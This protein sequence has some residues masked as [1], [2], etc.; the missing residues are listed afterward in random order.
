M[1]YQQISKVDKQRI[2]DA[3]NNDE[4]YVE[5]ARL[6][7]IKRTTAWAI[8]RRFLQTGL[9]VR[10]RGGFRQ[11][12]NKV[13]DEMRNALV[14]I[15]EEHSAFT[16]SQIKN[17]LQVRLPAKPAISIASV[18]KI[19]DGQLMRMKKL[20]DAPIERNSEATKQARQRYA[21]WMMQEGMNQH[22]VFVDEAGFNLHT[23]RTR[24]RARVGERAVR[25][26]AGSRGGNLNLLMAISPEA[27]M[28]Y[29]ELH[30]GTVNRDRFKDFLDNLG[31]VLGEEFDVSIVMDNAPI[32]NGVEMDAENHQ[33]IKLPAYSPM[34]NPIENA[35][36]SVKS[37]VKQMLNARMA[38]ILDRAAAA[39]AHQTLT[40]YRM[41]ILRQ[42]V[43]RA[44]EDDATITQIKCENWYR[45]TFAHMPACI[46]M[47]DINI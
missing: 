20:E 45:H 21:Q 12:T 13:D 34:L 11:E 36:S 15:V 30:V 5:T 1:P 38:E 44:L 26:V 10:P 14:A 42:C 41:G 33:I 22:L 31:A 6:L 46:N 37:A 8:I 3:H 29:F 23:R 43:T 40:A 27:G 25:Q 35:F 9:V 17:E 4:D 39:A 18:R 2:V 28:H 24:G 47:Q 19:L 7:G 32:H 16:L